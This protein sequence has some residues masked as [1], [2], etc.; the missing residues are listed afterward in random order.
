[1][2]QKVHRMIPPVQDFA[3]LPANPIARRFSA[4]AGGADGQSPSSAM[5]FR[6]ELDQK[7][8]GNSLPDKTRQEPVPTP[9]VNGVDQTDQVGESP[10]GRPSRKA[11]AEF[12]KA[13]VE[14]DPA[15]DAESGLIEAQISMDL[16]RF[17]S[18]ESVPM[19]PVLPI[20]ATEF[21]ANGQPDARPSEEA[22][23]GKSADGVFPASVSP[24]GPGPIGD[25]TNRALSTAA[26]INAAPYGAV[27]NAA[28]PSGSASG[29]GVTE[30]KVA[31][32][33][34]LQNAGSPQPASQLGTGPLIANAPTKYDEARRDRGD[35]KDAAAPARAVAPTAGGTSAPQAATPQP[36]LGDPTQ[37]VAR[38]RPD[39]PT[40][41]ALS[42]LDPDHV[43]DH[44]GL[45]RDG[46]MGG[47]VAVHPLNV[48]AG[49]PPP[50]G[51]TA[52]SGPGLSRQIVS[53]L[54]RSPDGAVDLTLSPEELGRVRLSLSPTESGGIIVHISADRADTMDMI[55][56]HIDTLAQDFRAI[57]YG[58]VAFGFSSSSSGSGSGQDDAPE[59]RAESIPA[60][61]PA[62]EIVLTTQGST[63]LDL[64]L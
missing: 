29:A 6:R 53:A 26:P 12:A 4:D 19:A 44:R 3:Q 46:A 35:A 8:I 27:P 49:P 45:L 54:A 5:E 34:A 1:M 31:V 20:G 43:T 16:S 50:S 7:D 59:I 42:M 58:S 2:R 21:R 41:A 33:P 36:L 38:Q 52:D 60:A 15:A 25:V 62:A 57:G 48:S 61:V 17:V 63:G 13:G 9:S 14:K 51:L 55:R 24:N 47:P 32:P 28:S 40:S 22:A 10:S 18:G 39:L 56:R 37:D 23:G 30:A 64:R 11:V